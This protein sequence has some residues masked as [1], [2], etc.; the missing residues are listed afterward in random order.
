MR[1]GFGLYQEQTQKLMMT[2]ELRLAIKILQFSTV[3]LTE[4]IENEL[5]ENPLLEIAETAADTVDSAD[6]PGDIE[7]ENSAE[8][9]S[10]DE[11]EKVDIDWEQYFDDGTSYR[12]EFTPNRQEE[13]PRYENFIAEVPTLQEYL[14]FQLALTPL[15]A[16][17]KSVGEF[18]IGNID[19]NGYLHCSTEETAVKCNVPSDTAEKVLGI[20]QGME[21]PE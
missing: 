2:P 8:Q 16:E 9:D 12:N 17:E 4:Y 7:R 15:G 3:E 14:M 5:V 18:F 21:P 20:I 11:M 1:M 6:S 13:T 19:D 10:K